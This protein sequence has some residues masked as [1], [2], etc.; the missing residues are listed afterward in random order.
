MRTW[1][2]PETFP[3]AKIAAMKALA[4]DDSLAEA[5][6]SLAFV[7]L[8]Y[9]RG[10]ANA[11]REFRR[12]I[13]L[14]PNYANGPPLVRS[15]YRWKDAM[16]KPS[17]N[18]NAPGNSTRFRP[19]SLPGWVRGTSLRASTTG[20][21]SSTETPSRWTPASFPCISCSDTRSS[22]SACTRRRSRS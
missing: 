11:E 10:W 18:R 8:Y 22:R 20:L 3:H 14:N 7:T 16:R 15:S 1:L 13:E 4:L 19:L 9:D 17:R 6:T 21:S 12:A 5:H 2:H